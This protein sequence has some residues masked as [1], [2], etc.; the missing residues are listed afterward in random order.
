M[1]TKYP[2]LLL[3]SSFLAFASCDVKKTEDGELPKVEVKDGKLPKYDV[4]AP[5]VDI[6]MEKKT[7]EVPTIDVDSAA[8]DEAEDGTE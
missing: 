3:A 4:D 7:I 1:K 2:V 5:D 6:E 8:E